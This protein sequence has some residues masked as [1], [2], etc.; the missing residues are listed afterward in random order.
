[1]PL[2]PAL[3]VYLVRFVRFAALVSASLLLCA[4]ATRPRQHQVDYTAFRESRPHSILIM[5]PINL[6]PD[7]KAPASF[8]AT[9]SMPLA[10]SGYYVIPVT[11]SEET[12]KQNGMTVA[13][14]AQ[15]IDIGKLRE[16][17]GADAAIYITVDRFGTSYRLLD[18]VVEVSASAK[19]IDLRSGREL[20]HGKASIAESSNN[21]NSGGLIGML[22]GAVVN[23]VANTLSDRS[24]EVTGKANYRLLSA[25][26][27]DSILYGPYHSKAGTD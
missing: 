20:W 6:S 12:F 5:P 1:M 17:F 21:N 16:I 25:G 9:A 14:E 7:E 22:V 8:L 4:C 13:D 11:L 15:N 19:L 3:R 26:H 27:W 10:E 23:Q 24:H 18:S 2:S